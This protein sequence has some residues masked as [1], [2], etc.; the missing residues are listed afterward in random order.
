MLHK[1]N[2]SSG[3]QVD[4]TALLAQLTQRAATLRS[5]AS[6]IASHAELQEA[7]QTGELVCWNAC[8]L[9]SENGIHRFAPG[10]SLPKLDA[11][12][13]LLQ[14]D[15]RL[16]TTRGRWAATQEYKR[17]SGYLQQ[18]ALASVQARLR[19]ATAAHNA[20]TDEVKRLQLALAKTQQVLREAEAERLTVEAE[21][22]SFVERAPLP[23]AALAKQT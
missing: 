1:N 11:Q 15:A 5:V 22:R 7:A 4:A 17:L 2:A 6:L 12:H 20:A 23:V 9:H 18:E 21:L 19:H 8:K 10:E 3:T 16:V 14:P 13:A